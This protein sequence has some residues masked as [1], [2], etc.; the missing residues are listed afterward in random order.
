MLRSLST[1]GGRPA[2]RSAA[3]GPRSGTLRS[4]DILHLLAAALELGLE[5]DHEVREVRV[6]GLGTDRVGFAR[7]LLEQEVE[8]AAHGLR[9]LE[10]RAELREVAAH[11][12]DLLG[13]VEAL[14]GQGDLLG[15][16][17]LV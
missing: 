12:H 3:A 8:P 17:R 16:A 9:L 4:L 5:L 7:K 1:P 6:R 10:Q 11:A 13:D 14:R 2:S 15:D